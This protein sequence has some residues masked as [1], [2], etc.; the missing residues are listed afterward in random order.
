LDKKVNV[1]SDI[2]HEL[3]ITIAYDEI[4]PEIE[5][6]YKEKQKTINLDGFRKGKV[7]VQILKQMF[8]DAIEIEASE[9][10]ANK[11]F[12]DV[13]EA[14]GLKPISTP[15]LSDID[16]VKGDKL[17]FKVRYEVKPKLELKDYKGLEIEK[18]VF[19]V[20]DEDIENEINY[21]LKSR[22]TFE[23]AD[24]IK[25]NNYRI[26]A[27]LQRFDS[28]GKPIEGSTAKDMVIDLSDEKV[29][30]E[31]PESAKGKKLNDTFEF[32][33]KDERLSE[34]KKISEE[35]KYSGTIKKIEKM[36][37]PEKNEDFFK[38]VSQNKCKTEEEYKNHLRETI[39]NY[40]SNQSENMYVNNLLAK[41]V[42]NNDFTAPKGYVEYLLSKMIEQEKEQAKKQNQPFNEIQAKQTLAP[43]AEW[44]AKWQIILE[45]L[46]EAE[47]IKVEDSDLESLAEKESAQI[48]LPKEKLLK[49]YKDTN[50]VDSLLEQKVIDFLKENNTAKEISAEEKAKVEEKATAEEKKEAVKK[51][52]KKKTTTKAASKK[53]TEKK[54]TTKKTTVKK[55]AAKKES[56]KTD[57]EN[58]KEKKAVTKKTTTK[59]TT[60]K[61]AET[62]K[63]D[64]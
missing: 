14:D 18:V 8:G 62:K 2:E 46:V 28:D 36:V 32:T 3:Q 20:K 58:V 64:K 63:E 37:F 57:K 25:D 6:A 49:Y 50:R 24:E 15:V 26:V 59:K 48:G 30:K 22:A 5:Q 55:V 1:I 4:K 43:R 52:I 9:K 27:D 29:N 10:I 33:F 17:S 61:K 51:T 19:S 60:A 40:Y 13:V 12:W 21:I 45:N 41:I 44:N 39:E 11:K 23:V 38:S 34:D 31:I 53:E 54:A 7:P 16:F 56:A 42:E 47:N 35:F